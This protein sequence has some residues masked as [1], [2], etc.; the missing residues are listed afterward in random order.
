MFKLLR[1]LRKRDWVCIVAILGLT[2]LQVYCTMTLTDYIGNITKSINYL[3]YH[4]DIDSLIPNATLTGLTWDGIVAN[5]DSFALSMSVASGQEISAVKE[6]I[7]AIAKASTGDIWF[8]AGIMVLVAFGMLAV[9]VIISVLS[10]YIASNSARNIRTALNEKI[11]SFSL[12]EI[13]K[14]STASLIT[15]TTNDVNNYQFALIFIFRMFFAAPITAI[16]AILKINTVSWKLMLPTLV[17]ILLL[18]IG[19]V[20][21]LA[22]VMPKFKTTQKLID[23]L[24]MV[25]RENLTGTRVVRAYNGQEY[26]SQKF[27]KANKDLTDIQLFTG[28]AMSVLS[29]Y[30]TLIMNMISLVLYWLGSSMINDPATNLGYSQILSFMML[31]S[32]IVMSFMMLLMMFMMLPRAAVCANRIDEVLKTENSIKDPEVEEK[33][34]TAGQI[35]FD[36]VSFAYPDAEGNV[37]EDISFKANK[38]ETLAIIGAT[39][40]GKTTIINLLTRLYDTTSGTVKI[41]GVDVKNIKN[42]TLRSLM[43][44]VP[45][46]GLLFKGTV[47]ENVAL[48]DEEI[49]EEKVTQFLNIAEAGF[50]SEMSGNLQASISAGG[51]NVSGGQRQRL[52][53]ARAIYSKPE[54]LV[55]DDSFSALDFKTDQK[56]R[57]NLKESMKDSTKVI[58]AQRIGT[59]MDADHIVVLQEGKMVGYGTHKELLSDCQTYRDIALSQ[60]SKEE[61]GL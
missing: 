31:S 18:V 15:R 52:C 26:Q 28:T 14:F 25:T 1:Y 4:N 48:R 6:M 11:A 41:D 50:V 35:E 60:L 5:I 54:I 13:D 32:Q 57:E 17:G 45:Q 56:V 36:D 51:T 34:L 46:K 27:E 30:I 33:L 3:A 44:V 55:F 39:G 61:L 59:I 29:P 2:F 58:V 38:G 53:I 24:N 9:Q 12:A 20:L 22:L 42:S 40:C 37:V 7:L 16:W 43:G 49:D 21:L 19:L 23:R 8:N 10:A 47:E